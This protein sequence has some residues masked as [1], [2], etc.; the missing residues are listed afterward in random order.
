MTSNL[1]LAALCASVFILNDVLALAVL[2]NGWSVA[3]GNN[4]T[5]YNFG[6]NEASVSLSRVT[7]GNAKNI[8]TVLRSADRPSLCNGISKVQPIPVVNPRGNKYEVRGASKNCT[9]IFGTSA[10]RDAQEPV[11]LVIAIEQANS[12][13]NASTFAQ[14]LFD[15]AMKQNTPA[16]PANT[17][18]PESTAG[19]SAKAMGQSPSPQSGPTPQKDLPSKA[20]A[21]AKSA[22]PKGLIGMWRSDWV[23][24]Q[25]TAFNGLQ[26]MARDN[27]LIF[28]S[29]GYFFDD[30]PI[31]VGFDDAGA[32]TI[33]RTKPGNAGR[34][35]VVGATIQLDYADGK[36]GFVEAVNRNNDWTLTYHNRVMSAKLTFMAGG[37]LSGSYTS[38]RISQAGSTFVVGNND[39]NF[40]LD[41]R[42]AKGGKVSMTS[43]VVSSIGKR[44]VKTGRYEIKASALYLYFDDGARE[45]YSMFQETKAENIWLN[46][47]MYNNA[48]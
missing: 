4:G 29:G 34:Y 24:N 28:T 30:V 20:Y 15:S 8:D 37:G 46:N 10:D 22:E 27:T 35:K 19:N 14:T 40:S 11:V 2:P 39:Y 47:Q 5:Q 26:L 48:K 6:D 13:S 32:Q 45:V 3:P 1:R 44:N 18:P 9:F 43:D 12:N 41:G 33:M 7:Q 42:F 23:E 21:L 31:S 38:E 25:F 17:S 16:A 36:K